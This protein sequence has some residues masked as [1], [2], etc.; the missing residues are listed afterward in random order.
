MSKLAIV[1][2]KNRAFDRTLVV[3]GGR[4]AKHG[5]HSH[6][7][8][9]TM[10]RVP[11]ARFLAKALFF[12]TMLKPCVSTAS[13]VSENSNERRESSAIGAFVGDRRLFFWSAVRCM[14]LGT[15]NRHPATVARRRCA[16]IWR[17]FQPARMG[18][19]GRAR[20]AKCLRLISPKGNVRFSRSDEAYQAMVVIDR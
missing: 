19:T 6:W 13:P 5:E 3:T 12:S 17:A 1:G 14:L 11:F 2:Q 7:R 9:S 16:S 8:W 15:R 4:E 18:T 20:R 10:R